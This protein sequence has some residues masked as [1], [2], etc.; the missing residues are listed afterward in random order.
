MTACLTGLLA[1]GPQLGSL[2]TDPDDGGSA[3]GPPIQLTLVGDTI[4]T[5]ALRSGIYTCRIDLSAHVSGG[6]RGASVSWNSAVVTFRDPG[7]G[8]VM[9]SR[10]GWTTDMLTRF[11]GLSA[12][13]VAS[14][15]D[16]EGGPWEFGDPQGRTFVIDLEFGYTPS[17]THVVRY[18]TWRVRCT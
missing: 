12:P 4:K 16:L 2:P 7:P 3:G 1:C 11:F 18:S 6:G 17:D 15:A 9:R 8:E 5:G 13:Q 10:S 14:P